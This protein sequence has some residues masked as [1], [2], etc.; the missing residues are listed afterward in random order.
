[1]ATAAPSST[2]LLVDFVSSIGAI[3]LPALARQ[4]AQDA[5][6]DSLGV[7]LAGLDDPAAAAART[8]LEPYGAEARTVPVWGTELRAVPASAAWAN[9]IAVHAQDFNAFDNRAF[10]DSTGVL[11]PVVLALGERHGVSG[12]AVVDAFVAG[13]EVATAVGAAVGEVH[14]D[15]GHHTSGTINTL[16]A[17]ASAAVLLGLEREQIAWAVGIANS[18]MP[19]CLQCNYGTDT[20]PLHVGEAAAAGIRAAGLAAAGFTASTNSL[21]AKPYGYLDTMGG[22][23][24]RLHSEFR[25]LGARWRL[26]EAPPT[27]KL[28]PSMAGTHAS[29]EA[30]LA[31]RERLGGT[32]V[33]ARSV[34][35]IV[36][37][38]SAN[39][40]RSARHHD[41]M[42][43]LEGK[44]SLE[45]C[46]ATALIEGTAGL[47]QFTDDA[48][49]RPQIRELMQRVRPEYHAPYDEYVTKRVGWPGRVELRL[50]D[51]ARLSEEVI[52]PLGTPGNPA[53]H[54]VIAEKFRRCA[55]L[56]LDEARADSIVKICAALPEQSDVAVLARLLVPE[57]A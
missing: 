23:V 20:K 25:T 43:G 8:L 57:G 17:A 12:A 54:E 44:F 15:K 14:Y 53:S 37:W 18:V 38:V 13:H 16:A 4:R 39:T 32:G 45:Y 48:V 9:G 7:A 5:I 10:G 47:D 56:L 42:T 29:I 49:R 21:D 28:F 30:T 55:A 27:V 1:M 2:E 6:L 22:E 41:P 51:G 33:A 46:V 31:L 24:E 36:V 11:A 26:E 19:T 40:V 52:S 34:D 50:A 35:E 3:E